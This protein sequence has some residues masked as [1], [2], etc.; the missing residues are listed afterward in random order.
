MSAS[1]HGDHCK[2]VMLR[3]PIGVPEDQLLL[4]IAGGIPKSLTNADPELVTFC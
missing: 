2:F 3:A 1:G 4:R